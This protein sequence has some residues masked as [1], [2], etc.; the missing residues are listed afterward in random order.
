MSGQRGANKAI[1]DSDL[2]VCLGTHLAIPHT[3]TLYDSYVKKAKKIILN[4]NDN[5]I[6]NLNLK[7]D[8]NISKDV[9]KYFDW[10][11]RKK[12]NKKDWNNKKIYKGMN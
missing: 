10:L 8:L 3:T 1:F 5:Q 12:I 2:I 9:K 6:N 11:Y 7:F 4:M